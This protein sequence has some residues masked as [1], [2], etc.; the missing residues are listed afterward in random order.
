MVTAFA[1]GALTLAVAVDPTEDDQWQAFCSASARALTH[2]APGHRLQ[3]A[4]NTSTCPTLSIHGLVVDI[5]WHCLRASGRIPG[6]IGRG[7]R[8][9]TNP[10]D[11][12][13]RDGYSACGAAER[14]LDELRG[15]VRIVE[16]RQVRY[17]SD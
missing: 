7:G 13:R 8:R 9:Q 10:Y 1:I 6:S 3:A 14:V 11:T 16:P 12:L 17:L 15:G 2:T 4:L 5:G